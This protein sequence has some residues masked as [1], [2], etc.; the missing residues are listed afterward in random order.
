MTAEANRFFKYIRL[1]LLTLVL[2]R[3]LYSCVFTPA[4]LPP[5][6]L[7]P[8]TLPAAYRVPPTIVSDQVQIVTVDPTRLTGRFSLTLF[9]DTT[10]VALVDRVEEQGPGHFVWIG[11]LSG[12]RDSLVQ[13]TVAEQ[14]VSGFIELKDVHYELQRL[15][16]NF[17]ALYTEDVLT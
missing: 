12:Q 7:L 8:A 1:L 17:Y 2:G 3:S 11:H 14:V 10:Y 16:D 15:H 5:A 9:D 6:L 13:V 4:A